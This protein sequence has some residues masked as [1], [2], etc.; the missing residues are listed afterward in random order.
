MT[1]HKDRGGATTFLM[2]VPD[3]QIIGLEGDGPP[4]PPPH[5]RLWLGVFNFLLK[6]VLY[7]KNCRFLM[8]CP[9]TTVEPKNALGHSLKSTILGFCIGDSAPRRGTKAK[10]FYWG[11]W[12]GGK[13]LDVGINRKNSKSLRM[14]WKGCEGVDNFVH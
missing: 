8:W 13:W 4:R 3:P 6:S 12:R 7:M 11:M 10:I 14:Q 9:P 1:K 5:V 2:S